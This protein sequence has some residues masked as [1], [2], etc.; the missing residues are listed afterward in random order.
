MPGLSDPNWWPTPVQRQPETLEDVIM[1][2][3]L[4][5]LVVGV[6]VVVL[7][8]TLGRHAT[9]HT[10]H[11]AVPPPPPAQRVQARAAS[12]RR[13][14]ED[15]LHRLGSSLDRRGD[16]VSVCRALLRPP[17]ASTAPAAA[18]IA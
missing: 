12:Q 15:C 5:P 4:A 9:T 7:A 10:A 18:P 3:W 13:E 11:Q 6:A 14:L 2:G 17:A 16:A 1:N 8:L